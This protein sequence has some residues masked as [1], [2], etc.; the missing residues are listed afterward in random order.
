MS[1]GTTAIDNTTV[2]PNLLEPRKGNIRILIADDHPIVRDGLR[3][4]LSLEEDFEIVGE[5]ADGREAVRMTEELSPDVVV[6]DITMPQLNGIDAASQIV[7]RTPEIGIVM[8]SM[9]CDETFLVRALAAGA[10]GYLLKD[11]AEADL[12]QAVRAVAGKRLFFSPTITQ[13][14][15]EDYMRQ[16]Q[17]EGLEDSYDLLTDREKEVLQLLAEGKSNKEAASLLNVSLYT[18]ETHRSRLM[19]KLNLHSTADIVL[20]AVRKRIIQ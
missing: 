8:L 12:L 3:K 16:M 9:H 17:N 19:Q 11:C 20:Y 10:Q 14:L 7:K 4:L 1:E 13:T 18:V 15:L 5:A 2:R 6:M